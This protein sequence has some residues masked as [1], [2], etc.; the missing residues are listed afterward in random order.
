MPFFKN[1]RPNLYNT[2][3]EHSSAVASGKQRGRAL[4]KTVCAP[5]FQFTLFFSAQLICKK[6][7]LKFWY[8]LIIL[9]FE[10]Y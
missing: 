9:T 5:Q 7:V 8:R 10:L 4:L 3:T 1:Q 2:V 6:N